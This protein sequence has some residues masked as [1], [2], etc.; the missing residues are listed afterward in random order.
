MRQAREGFH[1]A[2]NG[3]YIDPKR[4]DSGEG[5]AVRMGLRYVKGL[6][7]PDAGRIVA[8]RR[9]GAYRHMD[10]LASRTG[11]E[12]A[13]LTRLAESGAL[14]S[15]RHARRDALWEALGVEGGP[16]RLALDRAEPDAAFAPLDAFEEIRWDYAVTNHST[17]GHPLAPL[18]EALTAQGLPDAAGVH[19]LKNGARVRY[20]GLVI[21]RQRPGTA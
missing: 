4:A 17:R 19:R 13:V 6:R 11:L 3:S 15:L 14:Q 10:D 8:A 1:R 12:A 5:F 16:D 18:R 20:A 9:R 21:C 7:E 2:R